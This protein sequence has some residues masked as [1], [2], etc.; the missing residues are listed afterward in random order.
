MLPYTSVNSK[1]EAQQPTWS[2]STGAGEGTSRKAEG[3]ADL[4]SRVRGWYLQGSTD[5]RGQGAGAPLL[6]I[7]ACCH[8]ADTSAWIITYMNKDNTSGSSEGWVT[9]TSVW[10]W[11]RGLKRLLRLYNTNMQTIFG[12]TDDMSLSFHW[13]HVKHPSSLRISPPNLG[14][15][16]ERESHFSSTITVDE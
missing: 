16:P 4:R 10:G 2:G 15:V 9:P 7:W 12:G 13:G 8:L 11:A 5:G 1:Y 3:F 6:E 14:T